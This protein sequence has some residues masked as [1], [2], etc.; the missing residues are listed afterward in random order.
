M[1]LQK[2][3]HVQNLYNYNQLLRISEVPRLFSSHETN[4][5]IIKCGALN[6]NRDLP[7]MECVV[8]DAIAKFIPMRYLEHLGGLQPSA[9]IISGYCNYASYSEIRK[10]TFIFTKITS[11]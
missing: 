1:E 2:E 11:P 7:E 3:I 5:D 9:R 8:L 10:I 4:C 6:L